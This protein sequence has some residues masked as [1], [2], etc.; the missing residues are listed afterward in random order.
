VDWNNDGEWDLIS[1]DRNGYLNVFIR[2]GDS[3]TAYKQY[4]DINGAIMDIGYNSEPNLFDWNNDGMRDLVTGEQSYQ[5]RV[6]LNEGSDT[7][8]KF[9]NSNYF[10][11]QAGGSQVYFY[12]PN[13][14]MFDL[15][16]DGLDDLLVGEN[17]GYVH[18]FENQG[19]DTNPVFARGETLKLE[20]GRPARWSRT[21]YYYGSR[22]GFGDWNND[23]TPDFLLSTYEGQVELYL[24]LEP[25]G[26]AERPAMPVERFRVSP[27]PGG[28]PVRFSLGL[29]RRAELAV[30]D[31]AGRLVRSLGSYEPGTAEVSWDGRDDRGNRLAAGVY[32]C[33]LAAGDDTRIGRVVLAR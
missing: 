14:Y 24:G 1:G 7:W 16:G 31:D 2:S 30:M 29:N 10:L 26:V 9:N 13:P 18:Y 6:Y 12:R 3:L 25:T 5:V 8:P 32:F 4:T 23:G 33:R 19:P 22:C 27:V 17:N 11:V 20:D 21:S 28:P 15:N